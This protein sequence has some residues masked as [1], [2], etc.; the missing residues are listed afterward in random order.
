VALRRSYTPWPG[1]ALFTPFSLKLN[2]GSFHDIY[3]ILLF[4]SYFRCIPRMIIRGPKH[5][6]NL[7]VVTVSYVD[8]IRKL[9]FLV[10]ITETGTFV[11][12]FSA[13]S[14]TWTSPPPSWTPRNP[15]DIRT[16][17]KPV[18]NGSTQVALRWS[19]TLSPGTVLVLTTFSLRFNDGSF[20]DI[21]TAS[22]GVFNSY[23]T[24]FNISRSELATLIINKATETEEAVYQCKVTT[25]SGSSGYRIQVIVTGENCNVFCTTL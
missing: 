3:V 14:V 20:D 21:G 19:Y 22:I 16:V 13:T 11:V 23:R 2:E 24:R 4:H 1:S 17:V 15:T 7:V 6:C 25:N 12:V 5:F 18:L 9:L 8:G 10:C